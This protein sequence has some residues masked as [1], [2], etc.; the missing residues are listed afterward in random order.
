MAALREQGLEQNTLVVFTSDHGDMMGDHGQ[1]FKSLGYEGSLH[2]PLLARWP[3]VIAP[4]TRCSE[5]VSL[6][7]LFP[8]FLN[9]AGVAWENERPGED[10][11][12]FLGESPRV[13]RD[14]A[15]SE[16]DGPLTPGEY[17]PPS[18]KRG[19][20]IDGIIPLFR[21]GKIHLPKECFRKGSDGKTID[22]TK[23]FIDEEFSLY[24]GKGSIAHEDDLDCM[25][26]LREPELVLTYFEADD[27]RLGEETAVAPVGTGWESIF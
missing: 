20:R 1:W 17:E 21:E 12:A 7:D 11:M 4:G 5:A 23:R 15:F 24:K 16:M 13:S 18:D 22:L 27:V 14:L 26:R 2:I 25:S 6:L 8:T 9:A 19:E 3:G 10:L